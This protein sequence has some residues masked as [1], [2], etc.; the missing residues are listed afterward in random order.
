M[1]TSFRGI[2]FKYFAGLMALIALI[3]GVYFSFFQSRGFIKTEGIENCQLIFALENFRREKIS[4]KELAE[5]TDGYEEGPVKN[6][7]GFKIKTA[8]REPFRDS[9]ET[10]WNGTKSEAGGV[11][12]FNDI[13]SFYINLGYFENAPESFEVYIS[14]P[15]IYDFDAIKLYAVPMDGYD[16]NAG[17]LDSRKFEISEW[18]DDYAKGTMSC[19]QNSIMYFSILRNKGWHIYIDGEEVQKIKDVN[20][21]FTGAMIPAGEHQVELKYIYPYLYLLYASTA[22]GLLMTMAILIVYHRKKRNR[23]DE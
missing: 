9:T 11:R 17:L 16:K 8:H 20:I 1:L 15:G 5:L 10:V 7:S 22:A 4:D 6:K 14:N 21:S 23:A 3:S 13:D 2:K 12:S 18:G 19:D